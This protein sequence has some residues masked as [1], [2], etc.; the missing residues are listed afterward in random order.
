MSPS[1]GTIPTILKQ[2]P[3]YGQ[4]ITITIIHAPLKAQAVFWVLL[5]SI[6]QK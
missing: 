4:F 6:L 1:A 5:L 3:G 2:K